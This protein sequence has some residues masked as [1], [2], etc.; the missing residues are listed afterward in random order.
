MPVTTAVLVYHAMR[1]L[2]P[3][4]PGVPAFGALGRSLGRAE[5][6]MAICAPLAEAGIATGG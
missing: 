5:D 3:V 4:L 6:P 2:L 1:L